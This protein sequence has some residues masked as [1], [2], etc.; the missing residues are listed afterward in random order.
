LETDINFVEVEAPVKIKINNQPNKMITGIVSKIYP[1]KIKN[2]KGESVYEVD[3]TS[4]QFG[5]NY[6]FGQT[7]TVLIKSK[8]SNDTVIIPNWLV[9]DNQFIWVME[10]NKPMMKKIEVGNIFD[11]QIIIL[12]GLNKN[13]KIITDPRF[14]VTK[15]YRN[16]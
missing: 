11:N 4:Q 2:S 8:Y 5:N 12:G 3:I 13:D 15:F 7:G 6:Q 10:N 16:I 1:E 9:I 14:L